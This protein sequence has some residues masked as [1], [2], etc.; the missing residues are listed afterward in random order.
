MKF[1]TLFIL[2]QI[3]L[4]TFIYAGEVVV[5]HENVGSEIDIVEKTHYHLFPEV[6]NF[7]N[8]QFYQLPD[9]SILAVVQYWDNQG[10]KIREFLYS[11]YE[12]YLLGRK[13]GEKQPPDKDKLEYLQRKYQP[14]F[15]EQHLSEVPVNSYCIIKMNNKKEYRGYFYKSDRK[16]IRLLLGNQFYDISIKSI[17][18]MKY[19]NRQE[20]A[21]ILYWMTMLGTVSAGLGAGQLVNMLIP[22][23]VNQTG[24]YY[25]SG[26]V[27]GTIIGYYIAP[28]IVD[29]LRPKTIIEFRKSKIKRLDS[30]GR[31][32]YTFKKMKG[33]LWRTHEEQD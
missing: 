27:I 5:V 2:F 26:A 33:K 6:K 9:D 19:W 12:V 31:L 15:A 14:L 23:P 8:A 11:Q 10:I 3:T 18:K 22:I 4:C 7:I 20:E 24:I 17:D 30:I 21:D 1:R 28:S 13:I 16:N 25:F 29:W 32:T